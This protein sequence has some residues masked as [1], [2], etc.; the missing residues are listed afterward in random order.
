MNKIPSLTEDKFRSEVLNKLEKNQEDIS[1]LNLLISQKFDPQKATSE[2]ISCLAD[3][4]PDF[5][6][7]EQKQRRQELE[8]KILAIET[9]QRNTLIGIGAYWG[10]VI[11]NQD[12]IQNISNIGITLIPLVVL[13]FFYCRY[14]T[15][16]RAIGVI[17][18]YTRGLEKLIYKN[19]N[20]EFKNPSV[21]IDELKEIGWE[22][23]WKSKRFNWKEKK[24]DGI[25]N[26]LTLSSRVF[27]I[28][29]A[30]SNIIIGLLT[31]NLLKDI[32]H[33]INLW[34]YKTS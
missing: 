26:Y 8:N 1:Q 19:Y 29:L 14:E 27:W 7:E 20:D 6:K 10:Y 24:L 5:L 16:S 3:L 31:T 33:V 15:L 34:F 9:D 18:T 17:A 32:I 22:S 30:V 23:D 28:F 25:P 13:V 21:A 2:K 4:A 11:L 12:K